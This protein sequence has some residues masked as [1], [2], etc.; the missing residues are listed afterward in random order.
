MEFT[1][2]QLRAFVLVA[3]HRSFARAADALF[4]TPSGLSLLIR[5]LETHVG[6]RLFDRTTRTVALTARG[7]ELEEVASRSLQ[8][9]DATLV[10]IGRASSE[11]RQTISVGAPP[12]I[13]CEILPMAIKA[14]HEQRPDLRVQLVDASLSTLMQRVVTG[15]LD[16]AVGIFS[17][18]ADVRRVPLFQSSLMVIRPHSEPAEHR[19]TTTWAALNGAQLISLPAESPLQMLID[20]HMAKSRIV[21][22]TSMVLNLLE[23]VISMVEAGHGIAII[24]SFG[25]PACRNRRV[26]MSRLVN[27]V[28]VLEHHLIRSRA[29]KLPTGANDFVAFLQSYI[30]QWMSSARVV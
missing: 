12:L 14:F 17:R 11:S 5:E 23:T 24:P 2:R 1:S 4:I 9:L 3:K 25:V 13:A 18:A 8:D 20:G 7:A 19:A 15:E 30:E 22:R 16:V 6:C 26:V 21:T 27:P 10:H 28:V 29:R